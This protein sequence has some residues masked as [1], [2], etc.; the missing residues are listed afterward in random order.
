MA[1]ALV[2][3]GHELHFHTFEVEGAG[4]PIPY[5]VDFLVIRGRR[6][7]P[8]E[9]KSSGYRRHASLDQ[10]VRRYG[11]GGAES[12]VL[13]PKDLSREGNLTYVPLYMSM[14]L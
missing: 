13:T 7:C 2:A 6:L 9:V 14:C 5:E 4:K 8:V 1:Q 10:F 12:Y 11:V 3:S